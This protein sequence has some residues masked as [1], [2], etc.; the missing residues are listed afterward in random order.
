MFFLL[1]RFSVM[2]VLCLFGYYTIPFVNSEHFFL[3]L[4]IY[5][6]H[7]ATVFLYDYKH[8]GDFTLNLRLF[9]VNYSILIAPCG[10][11]RFRG[12]RMKT[13][14]VLNSAATPAL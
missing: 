5:F 8:N 9:I 13:T 4:L 11:L 6:K 1:P 10:F 7:F 14:V 12:T 3:E 2:T